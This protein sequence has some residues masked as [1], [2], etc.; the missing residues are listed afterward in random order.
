MAMPETRPRDLLKALT[1]PFLFIALFGAYLWFLREPADNVPQFAFRV[2]VF[3]IGVAGTLVIL[4]LK[5]MRNAR[6]PTE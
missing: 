2:A 3:S 4:I 1:F 6:P 5:A